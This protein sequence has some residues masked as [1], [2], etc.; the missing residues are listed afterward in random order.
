MRNYVLSSSV[1]VAALSDDE[2][3]RGIRST[4]DSRLVDEFWCRVNPVIAKAVKHACSRG[5]YGLAMDD[6]A[7]SEGHLVAWNAIDL[8]DASKG[9]SL[10]TYVWSKVL[11]RFK[12]LARQKTIRVGREPLLSSYEKLSDDGETYST[13][14]VEADCDMERYVDEER[15]REMGSA[16]SRVYS[17][18][19]DRDRKYLDALMEAFA[20]DERKPVEYAAAK[21]HC[22]RQQV[23]NVLKRIKNSLPRDLVAEVVDCL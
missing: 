20:A 18:T 14:Y 16:Y 21:L 7:L 3:V 2:L 4:N 23:Y 19:S 1:D 5:C 15:D 6:D 22:S 9:A 13:D 17:A 10:K 12:D 8:F 11:F